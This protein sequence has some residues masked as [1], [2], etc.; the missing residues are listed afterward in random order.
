MTDIANAPSFRQ[1]RVDPREAHRVG[2]TGGARCA[3]PAAVKVTLRR[4]P[5]APPEAG[6]P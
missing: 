5:P 1:A 4:P 2:A 3:L 6:R